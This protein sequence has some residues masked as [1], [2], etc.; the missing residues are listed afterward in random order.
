MKTI[1]MLAT[2]R[3]NIKVEFKGAASSEDAMATPRAGIA[4][5]TQPDD[6]VV[7]IRSPKTIDIIDFASS[8]GKAMSA[9]G[10]A[11]AVYIPETGR[12]E[13]HNLPS[14]QKAVVAI[15]HLERER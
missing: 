12:F 1:E 11:Y 5:L 2:E 3:K 14:V 15:N 6:I 13:R 9:T 10:Y 7:G 8:Q 4:L